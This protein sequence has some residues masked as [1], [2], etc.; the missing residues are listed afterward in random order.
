MHAADVVR[1]YHAPRDAPLV[2][3]ALTETPTLPEL[4]TFLTSVLNIEER[5]QAAMFEGYVLISHKVEFKTPD[6]P[7]HLPLMTAF[8]M[9][10]SSRLMNELLNHRCWPCVEDVDRNMSTYA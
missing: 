8:G 2:P 9:S 6:D 4:A 1:S 5:T 7:K 3:T 10:L